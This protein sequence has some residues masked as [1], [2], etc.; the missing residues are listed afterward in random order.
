MADL[1]AL[2]TASLQPS[3]RKQAEQTLQSLSGQPGFLS[4]LLRLILEPSLERSV[5]LAGGIYI[6]NIAKHQWD[7]EEQRVAPA[8]KA[9]LRSQLVPAMLSLSDPADKSIRAQIAETVSLI[10]ALD[11]PNEW[12][13]LID[14]LVKALSPTNYH[15]NLSILETA[16]SMFRRWRSQMRS[17]DLF[18]EI[19]LVLSKFMEPFLLLFR[20]TANLLLDPSQNISLTSS[21]Q[22]YALLASCMVQLLEIF[23]DF[24]CHDLPPALEDAHDE[25]FAP[26]TGWFHKFIGWEPALLQGDAYDTQPSIPSLLKA[27]ILE[28]V[29]L[30]LKLYPEQ[31]QNTNS[32][33]SFVQEVW[34][35]V[36]S[37][38][39][40]TIADDALVSQSLRFIS[41]AIR[42][43]HYQALFAERATISSLIEGVVVP[44]VT[45]RDHEIEQFEDDPL[46]FV[47]QDLGASLTG[48]G[49]A[50][51][52]GADATRRQAAA[53]V[54]NAL[55]GSGHETLTTEITGAWINNGLQQYASNPGEHWRSKD[56]AV[57]LLTAVAS[58][59]GT[60]KHGVT[61]TNTL[62]DVVKFFSE[63]VYSDLEAQPGKV[64]AVLQ[65]DA[66]R[67]LYTFR[68]QLTKPQLL[69]VLPL[70]V[71]H[72]GSENYVTYT[73]AAITIDRILF[74]KQEGRLLFSHADIQDFA[75]PL[76]DA[77]FK[78]IESQTT[79]EKVA[80]NDHLMR[81]AM[82][83]IITARHTLAP[84]YEPLLVRL[85]GILGV[86]SKNPSN[87]HFDQYIFESLS[88]LM[89]FTVGSTP[90]TLQ[91]FEQA[92]FGPFT[93]ILQQDIDQYIP[94][95]FQVLAQMLELQQAR[96]VPEQYRSLLPFLLTPNIWQQKGS[97]P[98]LVKLLQAFLERD[99]A[100]MVQHGQLASVLAVVQ[101]RLVPSKVNDAWGFELLQAVVKYIAPDQLKPFFKPVILTLLTR[102]HSNK[103]DKYAYGFT[104]FLLYTMALDISGLSPDY[105][106]AAVEEIQPGLW[107]QLVVNF[108]TPQAPKLP[109]KD[110]KVAV[111]GMTKMLTQSSL[112]LQ[113]P[114]IQCWPASFTALAKLF[115]EPQYL[116]SAQSKTGDDDDNAVALTEIDYE[117]QTAG[118]QAAYS[119]LAAADTVRED[120]V[121]YVNNPRDFLGQALVKMSAENKTRLHSLIGA[122]NQ[123]AV[124]PFVRGL[125]EAGFAL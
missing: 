46:D 82:R 62:V 72:L 68:N 86:I 78:R 18:S 90:T 32:V 114:S 57:Y 50:A 11:F 125:G 9:Q 117:E 66:I 49:G 99:A 60:S 91:T 51:G 5:R 31:L 108:I 120:P 23:Y 41:T 97:I 73:Y 20:Q 22:S 65:A 36:G 39:L 109:H 98:G 61:S 92:L 4:S 10:A 81:C 35:L 107:S 40:P 71:R 103:T 119:R 44:N 85:V 26:G 1:P 84:V 64:H 123:D 113:E 28:V 17:N 105:V 100:Q 104:H 93:I 27:A 95:V 58:R 6:K 21:Q 115:M 70:L 106:I 48:I 33:E 76:L 56:S 116:Q 13:D 7:E 67:F 112:M 55:V 118:Y 75:Q 14:Q 124:G 122:A 54:L 87:P 25:F 110:R 16:H 89:R 59:G 47:R 101:Q 24:T 94:Y 102:L 45:F 80:E 52:A 63:H 42:M 53:D 69:S 111:V 30:F 88:A 12:P 83:V 43:G 34:S 74:I 37:N 3:Q 38:R 2:L 96:A 8:E 29:E 19:N 79:P 15:A 121:A 77:L